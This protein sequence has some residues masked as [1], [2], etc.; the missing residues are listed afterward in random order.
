MWCKSTVFL[1]SRPRDDAQVNDFSTPPPSASGLGCVKTLIVPAQA[2][3]EF[4]ER[5]LA[6]MSVHPEDCFDSFVALGRLLP[7]FSHSQGHEETIGE[8]RRWPERGA[9]PKGRLSRVTGGGAAPQPD[10][11]RSDRPR[12]TASLGKAGIRP[13]LLPAKTVDGPVSIEQ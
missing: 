7:A 12:S 1:A 4:V 6:A 3:D 10:R 11:R 9:G 5:P 2:Q 8:C 13:R